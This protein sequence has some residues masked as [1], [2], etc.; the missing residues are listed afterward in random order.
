MLVIVVLSI[1][2]LLALLFAVPAWIV[3]RDLRSG[4]ADPGVD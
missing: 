1:A 4:R 3:I 2:F